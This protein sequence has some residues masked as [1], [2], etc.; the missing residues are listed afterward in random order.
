MYAF[1]RSTDAERLDL[2]FYPAVYSWFPCPWG[3][4]NLLT[5][6]D[7][8][9]EELPDMVFPSPLR[10]LLWNTKVKAACLRG[11]ANR[12]GGGC[13]SILASDSVTWARST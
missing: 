8:I 10:R 4:P 6:H 5:L 11:Y 7:A 12:C 13:A 3:L 1:T 2:M 9:A